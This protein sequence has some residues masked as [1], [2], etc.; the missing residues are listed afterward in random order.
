MPT[1]TYICSEHGVLFR[2]KSGKDG[3]QGRLACHPRRL[4]PAEQLQ[5]SP[6]TRANLRDGIVRYMVS[7]LEGW[8]E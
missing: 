2:T 3:H 5:V 1:W 4:K 7:D 6:I 8:G